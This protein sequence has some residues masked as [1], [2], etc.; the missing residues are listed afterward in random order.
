MA[1]NYDG[2]N[3][4][5]IN[6]TDSITRECAENTMS[7]TRS[8]TDLQQRRWIVC[9]GDLCNIMGLDVDPEDASPLPR[10]GQWDQPLTAV[11]AT[12]FCGRMLE[13]CI[14][15]HVCNASPASPYAPCVTYPDANPEGAQWYRKRYFDERINDWVNNMCAVEVR[16]VTTDESALAEIDGTVSVVR[17]AIQVTDDE[18]PW[19]TNNPTIDVC[20]GKINLFD[21]QNNSIKFFTFENLCKFSS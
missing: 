7:S 12:I 21:L 6:V 9:Y 1:Q 4:G 14:R 8:E 20:R 17:Y 18:L 15:C 16:H 13:N 5:L 2:S 11:E 10:P 19:T 3:L